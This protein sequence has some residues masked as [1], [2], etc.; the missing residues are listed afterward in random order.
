MTPKDP[1]LEGTFWDKFWRP[2]RSRALLFTPDYLVVQKPSFN[3]PTKFPAKFPYKKS[4]KIHRRASAGAQG[5]GIA[6]GQIW[7]KNDEKWETTQLQSFRTKVMIGRKH[8]SRSV[9]FSGQNFQKTSSG[10]GKPNQRK[11]SS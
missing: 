8:P 5:E 7:G 11:V 9:I 3:I 4:R 10:P 1:F 6:N 2:I